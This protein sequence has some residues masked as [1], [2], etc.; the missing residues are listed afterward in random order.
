MKKNKPL[1]GA[2]DVNSLPVMRIKGISSHQELITFHFL[3]VF[4]TR[5][6]HILAQLRCRI[7]KAF[8]MVE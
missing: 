3:L 7:I 5:G 2:V 4:F 8:F 1:V 6:Q